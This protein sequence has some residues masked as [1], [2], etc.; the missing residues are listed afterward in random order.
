M[1]RLINATTLETLKENAT[2]S[3]YSFLLHWKVFANTFS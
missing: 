2:N 1:I 3:I